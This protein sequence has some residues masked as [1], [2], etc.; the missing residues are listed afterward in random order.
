MKLKNLTERYQKTE[1]R[2]QKDK[3]ENYILIKNIKM[4]K[5]KSEKKWRVGENN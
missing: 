1:R 5:N 4:Q 2:K 3:Q